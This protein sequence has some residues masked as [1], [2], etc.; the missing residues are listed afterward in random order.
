MEQSKV[1]PRDALARLRAGNER[2]VAGTRSLE[3]MLS[4]MRRHELVDGQ[5]P[6]ATILTCSDSRVPVE[7]LFDQGLGD[8]FVIR[9]AGN[10]VA[11]SLVGSVEYAAAVLG[12]ELVVV[13]GHSR[14]GAVR[15]TL[16][17][18]R[19][20]AQ[21]PS[22]NIRDIVDRIR[23]SISSLAREPAGDPKLLD[24]AVAANVHASVDALRHG[25]PLLEQRIREGGL[26]VVGATYDIGTGLVDFTDVP[27]SASVSVV[28]GAVGASDAS[29]GRP[30]ASA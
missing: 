3:A 17:V 8:L 15:T 25:S 16:D 29:D 13:M 28:P 24:R 27:E 26:V 1:T 10:V 2:F 19:G 7:L 20:Q 9:V 21:V 23:P 11:P 12:C 14:C 6:F 4:P 5:S 30:R 22:E 18:L